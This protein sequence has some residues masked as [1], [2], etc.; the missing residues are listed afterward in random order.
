MVA[1]EPPDNRGA[2]PVDAR[3]LMTEYGIAGVDRESALECLEGF[4]GPPAEQADAAEV[5]EEVGVGTVLPSGTF[6]C[7]D[8]FGM[9]R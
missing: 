1:I 8:G 6:A 5:E 4:P 2:A 7:G 3:Q 9:G